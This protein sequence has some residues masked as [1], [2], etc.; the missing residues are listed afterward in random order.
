MNIIETIFVVNNDKEARF[1]EIIPIS[2]IKTIIDT[3]LR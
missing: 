2:G 1:F 3:Q